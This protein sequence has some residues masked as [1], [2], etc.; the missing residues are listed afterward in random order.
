MAPRAIGRVQSDDLLVYVTLGV[1]FGGRLGYVLFY[2]PA[3]YLAH[4]AEVPAVW[5]GGMAFHGGLIGVVLAIALFA[6]RHGLSALAL[7]DRVAVVAPIGLFFGRIANF[8]NGEL[9]GRVGDVPW[10]M[11]FPRGGPLLRHPSQLYEAALEGLLLFIVLGVLVRIPA[12]RARPGL[13]GGV[14]SAGYALSRSFVEFFREPD[15]HLGFI[16]PGFS[17]GQLLSMPLL[18][19]GAGLIMLSLRQRGG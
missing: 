16:L 5:Q 9:F 4:P 3:Y 19:F 13:L 1:V 11:V 8:V 2:Q 18:L 10:A 6:R 14:F 15:A 12:V 17:M 7:G